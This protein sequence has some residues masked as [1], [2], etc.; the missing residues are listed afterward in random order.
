MDV[1]CSPVSDVGF[2]VNLAYGT[3]ILSVYTA[4]DALDKIQVLFN[5]KRNLSCW[6][7]LLKEKPNSSVPNGNSIHKIYRNF[8][9]PSGDCSKHHMDTTSTPRNAIYV[10]I[11]FIFYLT[12]YNY[13]ALS[14]C[15]E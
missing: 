13:T 12:K 11:T 6:Y 15:C 2:L 3:L 7:V 9:N 5:T 1:I 4:K 8:E 14:F 10:T